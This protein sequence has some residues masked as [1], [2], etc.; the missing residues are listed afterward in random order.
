[1]DHYGQKAEQTIR[2]HMIWSMGAGFIPLPLAD[3]FSVS[4]IQLNLIRR[5]CKIY[6]VDFREEEGKAIIT[7]LT[8]SALAKLGART[9]IKFIPVFGSLVGGVTMSVLSGAST[10]AVGQTFKFHFE[11]GGTILDIDLNRLKKDY[12]NTFEKGKEE[13]I[14]YHNHQNTKTETSTDPG[15]DAKVEEMIKKIAELRELR[16][17]NIITEEEYQRMKNKIIDDSDT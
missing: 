4:A 11:K 9:M 13:A 1:M 6:E 2:N 5:L 16:Q 14:K 17:E 15:F 12:H 8:S 3:L 10:Y 7:A